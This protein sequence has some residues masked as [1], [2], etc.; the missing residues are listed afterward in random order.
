[1]RNHVKGVLTS[2]P[3]WESDLAD[4]HVESSWMVGDWDDIQSLLEG[5]DV[6]TPAVVLAKVLL[7]MRKNDL[8]EVSSALAIARRTLGA[9]ITATGADGYRLTY[10]SVLNLHMTRELEL[11]YDVSRRLPTSSSHRRRALMDLSTVLTHRLDSTLPTFR[12]RE[13]ILSTRRVGFSLMSVIDSVH[14]ES[15]SE[16]LT[17]PS[18]HAELTNEVGST[19]LASA[20]IARKAGH[21]QTAYSAMLQARQNEHSLYFIESAKLTKADGDPL[22]A[23]YELETSM[24]SSGFTENSSVVDLTIDEETVGRIKGKVSDALLTRI[25]YADG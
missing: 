25:P 5:I 18:S 12:C 3:E 7:A 14:F 23:L 1:M 20:K 10:D 16:L 15:L 13:P 19:W 9:P 21:W 8:E 4:F 24:K 22:R 2:H 17:R 6:R 11:V